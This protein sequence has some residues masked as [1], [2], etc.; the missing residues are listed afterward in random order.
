MRDFEEAKDKVMMGAERKSMILSDEEKK[1]TAYHEAGHA[2][3]GWMLEN[4]DPIHKVTVIPRGRAL[5]VTHFLPEED[6]YTRTKEY[7]VDTMG[8]AMGGRAAEEIIFGRITTGASND[9]QR[10]TEIARKM[11]TEWGMSEKLGP[12]N[13]SNQGDTVFLGREIQQHKDYS[14]RT[15]ELI[16]TEISRLVNDAYDRAV[17]VLKENLDKLHA[18]A[19]ALL[20]RELLD[21]KEI[22]AIFSGQ[23]LD[24]LPPEE[25]KDTPPPEPASTPEPRPPILRPDPLPGPSGA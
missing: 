5:G 13:Y 20:D 4:A 12:L 25:P 18:L 16:D 8:V 22:A 15:A 11:V 23:P 3:V 1:T 9:I 2:L 17:T 7:C 24:P 10:V 6:H 14:E 21:R 19:Q